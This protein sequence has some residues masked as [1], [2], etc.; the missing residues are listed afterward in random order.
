MVDAVLTDGDLERLATL[1]ATAAHGTVAIVVPAA[2]LAVAAPATTPVALAQLRRYVVQRLA[3]EPAPVPDGLA[4]E[5]PVR[6]GSVTVG[7]VLLLDARATD[8]AGDVLH[9]AA[10]STV[11]ALALDAAPEDRRRAGERLLADLLDGVEDVDVLGRAHRAGADLSRG[12]I[13]ACAPHVSGYG[14]RVKAALLNAFPTALVLQRGERVDALLPG[15]DT[16]RHSADAPART[17][18]DPR[19]RSVRARAATRRPRA[20]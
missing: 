12:A 5:L 9:L 8:A 18:D 7:L 6:T 13:A 14:H 20:A 10:T 15:A 17:A 19:A 11:V 1:A 3:E 4:L 2:D 16:K